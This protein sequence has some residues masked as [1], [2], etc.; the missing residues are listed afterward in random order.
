MEINWKDPNAT[1]SYTSPYAKLGQN[2]SLL[3][4]PADAA[5]PKQ[6]TTGEEQKANL[7]SNP[8]VAKAQQQS[9][10]D[11]Q[12]ELMRIAGMRAMGIDPNDPSGL[13]GKT[14]TFPDPSQLNYGLGQGFSLV[15]QKLL[16]IITMAY[17]RLEKKMTLM[18][19]LMGLINVFTRFCMV[20][21]LLSLNWLVTSHRQRHKN[22]RHVT[23]VTGPS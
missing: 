5:P 21:T 8:T 16:M 9:N 10:E 23:L 12:K 7:D 4:A 14:G 15:M 11:A 1:W 3:Q 19:C 18:C 6:V 17:S 20:I 2:L 13:R 22:S